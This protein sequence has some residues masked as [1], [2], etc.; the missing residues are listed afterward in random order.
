MMRSIPKQGIYVSYGHAHLPLR[1]DLAYGGIVKLQRLNEIIPNTP[2]RFNLL[3]MVSSSH[4]P[5]AKQLCALAKRKGIKFVWNQN[6]VGY[7]AWLPSG[8]AELNKKMSHFY[9]GADYVFHQSK[10]AKLCAEK[11]FGKRSGL[12]EILYNAVDTNLFRPNGHG[13]TSNE[14][15]LLM[16]GT[17]YQIYPLDSAI[18]SLAYL[19]NFSPSTKLAVA[20]NVKKPVSPIVKKL[21]IDLKL[22]DSIMFLPAFSQKEAPE[23]FA[24]HD[25]LFH[26][27]IQDVCPGVV[28]EAMA[29]GLPVI[30]SL[31]GGVPELV[32][33]S[34]GIGVPTEADWQER[35]PPAPEMWAEA[36]LAVAED[37]KSFSQAARQIAV[38]RFDLKAWKERHKQVFSELL[39]N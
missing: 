11:F 17:F 22:E 5:F 20:G 29:C 35:I 32:G 3:Y 37:I 39:D 10:F 18:R 19:H 28:I 12:S 21:I 9:L 14:I 34:A 1:D 38:E 26:T 30:Y 36:I 25:I 4:P 8:W 16:V 2:N 33:S 6:G 13:R 31:S 23:I 24:K 7:P 15:K 27:K